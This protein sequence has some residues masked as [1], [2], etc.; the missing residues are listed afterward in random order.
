MNDNSLFSVLD[1]EFWFPLE[2]KPRSPEYRSVVDGVLP[3]GEWAAAPQGVWTYLQ[4]RGWNGARQGWKLHVSATPS[5]AAAV[6]ETVAAVLRDDPAAFKFASDP[7]ILHAIL[8]KNWPREGGG[9]F[10]TIYPAT[11]EHFQRLARAL[12]EATAGL[13]G[14]YI[15]SDRRV[16]GS[17][18]VFYRYGE[19]SAKEG[20]DPT[21][22]SM[23]P[24]AGPSGEK[25]QDTRQGYYTLPSWA[26][27]PYGARPVRVVDSSVSRMTLNGRYEVRTVMRYSNVGGIYLAHDLESGRPVVVRE[28]RPCVGW[29]DPVTDA[30]ALLHKEAGILRTMD[31]TGWTPALVD[32]FQLWEHHY[33][34]MEAVEGRLVRD[35]ALSRY[36]PR[37]H[38]AGPRH[39]FSTFRRLI[40]E[41]VRGIEEFHRRGIILRDLSV[42]N[43]LVRPDGSACFIDFEFAWEKGAGQRYAARIQ[44]PGFAS[45]QQ[46]AGKAPSEADDYHSLGAVVV[47][48]CSM[49]APGVGLNRAGV[50]EAAGMMM[51]EVGLPREL[52]DVARGLLDPDP[53][54]RWTGNEVRRALA[55]V[56]ASALPWR[57]A[58]PAR[59]LAPGSAAVPGGEVVESIRQTCEDVCGFFET[60][61]RTGRS[62]LW[63][64][65]PEASEVNPV[66]IRYGAC[67]P[68]EYVRR[69][70]GSCPDE[71][72]DWVERRAT[73][74]RCPPG[75]YIG[76]AGV[77]LTLAACGREE[78]ARRMVRAAAQDPLLPAHATLYHGA[79][80]VGLAALA[81]GAALDDATLKDAAARTGDELA[82]CAVRRRRGLTWPIEGGAVPSGL[83][84]G[85][86]GIS[87]FYTYL[88]A[89]TGEARYW[90][91]ARE[92]LD[93][94]FSQVVRSAGQ[95]F[96]P[97]MGGRRKDLASPHVFFG[98]AGIG[99][100]VVRLY[101]CTREPE[102]HQWAERC[103]EALTFRWTNKLWQDLG[104][105]GW[106]E[107]LLDM[108]AATGD[109]RWRLHALRIAEALLP[110]RVRTRLGTAFPG[111]GLNR[112]ASDFG[113]GTSGIAL[114]LHRLVHGGH[115]AFFPD[116]LLP[117]WPAALPL[118]PFA[119]AVPSA[120]GRVSDER[121]PGTSGEGA[122][123]RPA[124]RARARA[125]ARTPA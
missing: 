90:R 102:L 1:S 103:A 105:A 96:W 41:L 92:A 50:L 28:R 12:A 70:R 36:F 74:E 30:V 73:P 117:G 48:I 11:D 86:A 122:A 110:Y 52:L 19:H 46:M 125:R 60:G 123:P 65:T 95:V 4:P 26:E 16:P 79:A 29:I 88:G 89:C 5:N 32:A 49:L 66:C 2:L 13:D 115:R 33:L 71:W 62:T 85:G 64:A 91:I 101:A 58:E 124:G 27:D 39:L 104:Y 67:G 78:A 84:A 93:Y 56:R 23:H 57:A 83:G 118:K 82:R 9:K 112:V 44:T 109:E 87:L 63:P 42:E 72:L 69:V 55:D 15:L 114:F 119:E 100:A 54:A 120:P 3:P 59:D 111:G 61:A 121:V 106:G 94:E 38:V 7:S 81:V 97:A 24:L 113:G 108:H 8:S 31:G 40:L 10:I 76:R 22:A 6:L 75:L 34:V 14:P 80:G 47:E 21:G 107:T 116:H 17:R 53:A 18:I 37:G 25:T 98:S 43:V 51:D 35:F 68:L 20:V 99:T 45:P 77:A